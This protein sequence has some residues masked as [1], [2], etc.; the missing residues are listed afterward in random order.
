VAVC[1]CHSG[2]EGEFGRGSS[3]VLEG[4]QCIRG[5]RGFERIRVSELTS[6]KSAS[7]EMDEVD[8]AGFVCLSAEGHSIGRGV[9]PAMCE[10]KMDAVLSQR[11]KDGN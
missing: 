10:S 6:V 2:E 9:T 8:C 5:G 3:L 11:Q 4:S 7:C 1:R